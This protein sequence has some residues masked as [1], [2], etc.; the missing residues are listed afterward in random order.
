MARMLSTKELENL[1]VMY[2]GDKKRDAAD[3]VRGFL[4]QDYVTVMCL[5]QENVEFVCS[6]CLEDVD[7]FYEDGRFEFIQV[8]YYPK[9][10]PKIKEISTDLYYQY[11]RLKTLHSALKPIP[12]LFIHRIP[13]IE[14]PTFDKMKVFIGLGDNLPKSATYPS[15]KDSNNWLEKNVHTIQKKE[16]QKEKLFAAMASEESLREFVERYKID[17]KSN[18]NDYKTELMEALAKTY[19]S[20]G[21]DSERDKLVLLGLAIVYIQRR[22]SLVSPCFDQ[23]CVKKQEFDQYMQETA[24]TKTEQ[25]IVAY[26]IGAICEQYDEIITWNSVNSVSELQKHMLN[27]IFKNT[28]QWINEIGM[29]MEGQCQ[30]LNTFSLGKLC[31]DSNYGKL[32]A[33]QRLIKMAESKEQF[34]LFL[35]YLWK[36][37]LDISQEHVT[38]DS[39]ITENKELFDPKTY[40]VSSVKDYVCM[41]FPE[42][43]LF[44]YSVILPQG[45]SKFN[46]RK[47]IIVERMVNM[48]TKPEKWFFQNNNNMRGKNYYKYSTADVNENPT[49][50]DLGEDTFYIECMDCIGIDGDNWSV[51]ED[52]SKYIFSEKCV[53]EGK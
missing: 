9:T 35:C 29:K 43:K 2:K 37:M 15:T 23:L 36:I 51:C 45:G 13:E 39:K 16:A 11:L 46:I 22:Y 42:D 24:K 6:E 49:V 44:N 27:I 53:K 30:L 12:C 32:P 19:L 34:Q 26:L 4:F 21:M 7:V 48:P 52:C 8:K 18:I 17:H 1:S 50:A 38:D 14:K 10:N 25:T 28:I 3:K 20:L 33:E 40:I 41:C 5:L 31:T 47:R